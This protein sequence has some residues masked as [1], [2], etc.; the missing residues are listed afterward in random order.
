MSQTFS[1]TLRASTSETPHLY[2][3]NYFITFRRI[4]DTVIFNKG[5]QG[6]P[7][8]ESRAMY[9]DEYYREIEDT[10]ILQESLPPKPYCS[11]EL[12]TGLRI[13]PRATALAKRY[14]QLNP[15]HQ[16]VFLTFDL[17]YRTWAYVAEDVSLPQPIWC[18]GNEKNGHA[19]LIYAL[20][21]PVY[22][23][24]AAHLKPL[25]WLA[26]IEAAM[27]RKLEAD[28]MY[29]GLISKNPWSKDWLVFQTGNLLY[30]LEYLSE[31]V[32]L[33]AKALKKPREEV[34]GLGRNCAVFENVRIWAYREIRH[35][36]GSRDEHYTKWVNAVKYR[37]QEENAKFPE[38][39]GR[40]ELWQI[41]KSI[42]HWV[43]KR[44]KPASF[45]EWQSANASH[46]WDKA[47]QKET[48]LALLQSGMTT[49]EVSEVLG[50]SQRT[51]Q[52]WN[53]LLTPTREIILPEEYRGSE[54]KKRLVETEGVSRATYYRHQEE[55]YIPPLSVIKPWE[56]ENMSKAT[57]YRK[58]QK[59]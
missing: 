16:R 55:G 34:I 10:I 13:R 22:T 30:T 27:R 8:K 25:Q 18:V 23:T 39:L 17:D 59:Q 2:K 11:D 7:R 54:G 52:R 19:H 49:L 21:Y 57:W 15:P 12:K 42:S 51:C 6:K 9:E 37:C 3:Q 41:A 1:E 32:D 45:S 36:W 26:A 28:P 43:W 20:A 53:K 58:Q 35:H 40:P 47:S 29:S 4:V 5:S 46:R 14:I 48:G 56:A 50:V 24:S 31:W 38:P 33:S 44:M